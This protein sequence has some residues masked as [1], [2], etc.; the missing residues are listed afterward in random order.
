M[1][2]LDEAITKELAQPASGSSPAVVHAARARREGGGML[3]IVQELGDGTPMCVPL[4]HLD[5]Q[6]WEL[7]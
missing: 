7:V 6:D 4:G 1:V 3:C 5:P 2:P